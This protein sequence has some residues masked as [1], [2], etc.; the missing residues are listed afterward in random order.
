MFFDFRH[1][2][3]RKKYHWFRRHERETFLDV[4]R[5]SAEEIEEDTSFRWQYFEW[6]QEY[7][8]EW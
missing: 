3:D 6:F 4:L 2:R 7:F 5:P 1:Q 8:E